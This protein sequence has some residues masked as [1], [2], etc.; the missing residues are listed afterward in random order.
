MRQTTSDSTKL[1]SQASPLST[2]SSYANDNGLFIRFSNRLSLDVFRIVTHLVSNVLTI[3]FV[4]SPIVDFS[5]Q[6]DPRNM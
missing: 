6:I 1:K 3:S 2:E 5:V 4:P